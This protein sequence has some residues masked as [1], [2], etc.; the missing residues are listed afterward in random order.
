[1][2]EELIMERI[3]AGE[4]SVDRIHEAENTIVKRVFGGILWNK[5][6]PLA[7]FPA[8]LSTANINRFPVFHA[9]NIQ[10]SLTP[11]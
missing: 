1:M 4:N 9:R 6:H 8:S 10:S 5:V 3:E 7:K 2:Q 11:S